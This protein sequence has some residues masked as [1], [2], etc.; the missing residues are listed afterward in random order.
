M[1][2]LQNHVSTKFL[3]AKNLKVEVACIRKLLHCH[4]HPYV[5]SYVKYVLFLRLSLKRC[6]TEAGYIEVLRVI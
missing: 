3:K 1:R 2:F 4:R 6:L 5:I